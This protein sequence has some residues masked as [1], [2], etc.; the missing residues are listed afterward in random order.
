MVKNYGGKKT[1]GLAR[2]SNQI[3]SNFDIKLRLSTSSLEK[4]AIVRKLFGNSCSVFCDDSIERLA[5]ISGKFSGR[6]KRNNIIS[7][8]VIVLIGIRDWATVV[9]GKIEKCDILEIYSSQE[10]DLLKQR[11]SFPTHFIDSAINDLLG[12]DSKSTS[13]IFVFSSIED[14][15]PSIDISNANVFLDTGEEINIDDI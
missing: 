3:N 15:T 9:Q 12:Q 11:P 8:G 1:K 4:Y 7:P 2:K 5:M 6:N 14:N 13:D 10:L